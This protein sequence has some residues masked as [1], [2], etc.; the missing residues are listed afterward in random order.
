MNIIGKTFA[1]NSVLIRCDCTEHIIEIAYKNCTHNKET[2]YYIEYIGWYSYKNKYPDFYFKDKEDFIK[3]LDWLI[4]CCNSDSCTDSKY[5]IRCD[6]TSKGT[7]L[8]GTIDVYVDDLGYMCFERW[9]NLPEKRK[10]K[11][12]SIWQILIE[13][14]WFVELET[15]IRRLRY[16]V[17]EEGL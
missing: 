5:F 12:Y 8:R 7:K 16:K 14:D 2:L 15:Q 4:Y 3:F 13:R 11:E 10:K 1:N 9:K 17:L 6:E